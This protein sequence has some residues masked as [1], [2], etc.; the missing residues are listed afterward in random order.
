MRESLVFNFFFFS[1][2]FSVLPQGK[3]NDRE[4]MASSELSMATCAPTLPKLVEVALVDVAFAD[5]ELFAR[6]TKLFAFVFSLHRHGKYGNVLSVSHI[7]CR[8]VVKY[9]QQP[10]E[11]VHSWKLFGS[12]TFLMRLPRTIS[13]VEGTQSV[14]STRKYSSPNALAP[15]GLSALSLLV[16]FAL[17]SFAVFPLFF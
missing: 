3:A 13:H 15:S 8:A 16:F 4:R 7:N 10:P 6:G 17:F 14:Y 11:H 5:V 2:S 12:S 1:L 9:L